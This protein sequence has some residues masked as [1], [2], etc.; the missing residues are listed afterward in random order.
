M[1][2]HLAS[3]IRPGEG[4]AKLAPGGVL[5]RNMPLVVWMLV[6]ALVLPV[7]PI[8]ADEEG[9]D[10]QELERVGDGHGADVHD[11]EAR[12]GHHAGD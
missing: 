8:A 1:I 9:D 10:Q 5:V 6:L 7:V 2:L 12:H 4:F 11:D 3:C